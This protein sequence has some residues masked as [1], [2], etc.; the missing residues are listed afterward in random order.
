L[1]NKEILSTLAIFVIAMFRLLPSTNRIIGSLNAIK[2]Y[3]SSRNI[4]H[5]QLNRK[6]LK[7]NINSTKQI[8]KSIN[9]NSNIKLENVSFSY[10]S[11]RK[12]ILS[13]VNLVIN[14][15]EMIAIIGNNGSGKST[16]LNLIC[17]LFN[18]NRYL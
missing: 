9:F 4:I 16:L 13:N 7:L 17:C 11:C 3:S 18:Y 10:L 12:K 8:P 2:F 5:E 1:S 14:K 15:N 6:S